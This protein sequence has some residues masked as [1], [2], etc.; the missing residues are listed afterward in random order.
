MS[1]P[2]LAQFGPPGNVAV[3]DH[4]PSDAAR[5]FVGGAAICEAINPLPIVHA[6]K[7]A[8]YLHGQ[9][10]WGEGLSHYLERYPYCCG[11][12][13]IGED[14]A[15][16]SNRVDLDPVHRDADGV[17][18]PRIT[19]ARHPNDLALARFMEERMREIADA[20][21]ALKTFATEYASAGTGSG[22]IMGTCRMGTDPRVSVIDRWCRS[23]E[24]PNLWVVDGSFFP[25]SGGYN[26]TL[27]IVANAYRVAAH[28]VAEARRLNLG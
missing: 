4:H 10:S 26:A 24:V 5:G 19:L 3:D 17:A 23:H 1:E 27:T 7:F 9:R 28:F 25:S 13:A 22:H 20:G 8:D 16:A 14:L 18:L 15:Q 11:M 6:T 21:G 2:S 12:I